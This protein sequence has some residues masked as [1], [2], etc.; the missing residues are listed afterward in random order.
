M[1]VT[2]EFENA[3]KFFLELPKFAK[4]IGYASQFATFDHVDRAKSE[5]IL[6]DPAVKVNAAQVPMEKPVTKVEAETEDA[7]EAPEEP[8][9]EPKVMKKSPAKSEKPQETA[10]AKPQEAA[11]D[12]ETPTAKDTDVRKVFNRLIKSGKRDKVSEILKAHDAENF[13][14]L[15]P[16]YYAA[17]IKAAKEALGEEDADA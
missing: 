13:S 5:A 9:E 8:P 14:G 6:Q 1:K 16:K 12:S 4:L 7:I 11:K 10:K 3:E 15:D 2:L 17:A